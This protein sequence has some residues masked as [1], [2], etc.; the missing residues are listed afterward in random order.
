[1]AQPLFFGIDVGTT[2]IVAVAGRVDTRRGTVS[3]IEVGE[4]PSRGLKRGVIVDRDLA[5]EAISEAV[6]ECGL[7]FGSAVVGIAG[8]HISST[9]TEVT[10]LNRGRNLQITE[11]FV[12]KLKA[13]AG[14]I[15]PGRDMEVVQVVPKVFVLDGAEGARNPVGLAARKVTMRAHVVSGA[16]ASVQN[17][18][19]AVR[20]AGVKPQGVV[21]EPLA[22]ARA[23]LTDRDR[24]RGTLLLDIGGG[25]TDLAVFVGGNLVHTDVVPL[26]G[27]SL[28]A[29]LAYG[30][31]VPFEDAESIKLRYGS[32]LSGDI[33]PVAAVRYGDR[34]YNASYIAQILEYRARE[35]LDF[36]RDSLARAA[37]TG[38]LTGGVV[39]TGGGSKLDGLVE[40]SEEFFGLGARTAAPTLLHGKSKPL[41]EPEYATAVGLLHFA[42]ENNNPESK[43][44]GASV[45]SFD[46]IVSA[47][48]GWFGGGGTDHR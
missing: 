8:G 29:D 9:N 21:L 23:C 24:E 34:H 46:S 40:L 44:K 20:D 10:L 25:T 27:E 31:K 3:V 6:R 7:R 12:A 2:K 19:H 39:L 26:G 1:M 22:S 15:E 42:A 35:I 4:A 30:L 47:I 5:A 16:V 38:R 36:A 33:D 17:L 14:R 41:K 13:E 45:F 48:K 37:L 43:S 28:T 11:R 18:L 32:V